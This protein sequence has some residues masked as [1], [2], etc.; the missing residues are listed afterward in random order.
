M[1]LDPRDH[2]IL[3]HAPVV[4][5]P[6]YSDATYLE[7]QNCHR[8]LVGEAGVW[9]ELLRPWLHLQTL[10]APAAMP[11]PYGNLVSELF[12]LSFGTNKL[13]ALIQTFLGDARD[14]LPNE[15]AAWGVWDEHQ[16]RL[17]YRPC[18]TI[19]ATPGRVTF[20]RPAL[21]SHEHLAVDIHSHGR[22]GAFFSST[23]DADD[24]GAVKLSIVV[25][26]VHETEPEIEMRLC[27][28]GLFVD[29]TLA[30]L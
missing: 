9:L 26:A 10:I 30:D 28:L 24:R 22:I 13:M 16:E 25:G 2:I 18:A 5:L 7:E 11:L 15:C 1:P 12:D 3:Q 21:A 29:I 20:E 23:D 8:F 14:A 17:L 19:D 27:A 4:V 6:R